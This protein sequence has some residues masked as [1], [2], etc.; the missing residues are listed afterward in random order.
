MTQKT[1]LLADDSK[2][3]QRAA[4]M[5]VGVSSDYNLIGVANVQEIVAIAISQ[6]LDLIL[7]DHTLEDQSAYDIV[8]KLREAGV[9]SQTPVKVLL[10][11]EASFD[12]HRAQ[13]LG[14][15]GFLQKPFDSAGFLDAIAWLEPK[16]LP[17]KSPQ[18]RPQ[19][20]ERS[21]LE[22]WPQTASEP[23]VPAPSTELAPKKSQVEQM[24]KKIIEEIA[25]EV[26]PELAEAII[27]EELNRL[28]QPSENT[29]K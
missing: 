28:L 10:P 13:D 16:T 23:H 15:T 2:T 7:L 9:S 1:I 14:I 25:W 17:T 19:S 5:V 12:S 18:E 3:V 29:E 21:S 22:K 24:A 11:A 27:R 6:K 8:Q 4:Q 26:V 20:T